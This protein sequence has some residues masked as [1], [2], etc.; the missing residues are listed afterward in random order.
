MKYRNNY[1]VLS[2]DLGHQSG[3]RSDRYYLR[4]EYD[5]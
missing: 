3:Y 4:V 5:F 2:Y 1:V